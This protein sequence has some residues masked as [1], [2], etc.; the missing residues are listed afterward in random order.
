MEVLELNL[1]KL[2][3]KVL[4]SLYKPKKKEFN[5]YESIRTIHEID[6]FLD[7]KVNALHR[8]ARNTVKNLK[9]KKKK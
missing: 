8:N 6:N 1:K 4:V 5:P 9:K 2:K 7:E 3:S